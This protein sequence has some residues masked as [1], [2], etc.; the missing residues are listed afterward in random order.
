ML[1]HVLLLRDILLLGTLGLSEKSDMRRLMPREGILERGYFTSGRIS[2][3]SSGI[4]SGE[5]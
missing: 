5:V 3:H 2:S 4:E 1:L